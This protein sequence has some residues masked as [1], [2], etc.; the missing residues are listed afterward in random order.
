MFV[1]LFILF[2][3]TKRYTGV[4]LKETKKSWKFSVLP[5]VACLLLLL[6]FILFNSIPKRPYFSFSFFFLFVVT[7]SWKHWLLHVFLKYCLWWLDVWED[8]HLVLSGTKLVSILFWSW[9]WTWV[10]GCLKQSTTFP[11]HFVVWCVVSFFLVT[12][13]VRKNKCWAMGM[14]KLNSPLS[15]RKHNSFYCSISKRAHQ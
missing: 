15:R 7:R 2:C 1:F 12:G 9:F 5:W 10:R 8:L 3:L 6:L 13:F 4:C 14:C 11:K